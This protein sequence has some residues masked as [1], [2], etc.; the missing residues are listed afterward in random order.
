[1]NVCFVRAEDKSCKEP[2]CCVSD[3]AIQMK[4]ETK[5]EIVGAFFD[6]FGNKVARLREMY[7]GG[8]REEAF[9]L[10]IVYI[11]RLASGYYGGEVG[12]NRENFCRALKELSGNRLFAMLHPRELLEQVQQHFPD[13][14]SIVASITAP[15]PHTLLEEST[16]AAAITLSAL[17]PS[18][19]QELV[20]N[21]WRASIASICH[22]EIRVPEVHGAGSSGL[23]FDKTVYQGK[24]GL[25]IDFDLVYRALSSISEY[26]RNAS[27]ES[28]HWFG[29][30]NYPA[31][32]P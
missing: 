11:D 2:V 14:L 31:A 25:R 32:R 3:R 18:E 4:I 28:G 23:D 27:V 7:T 13:A 19:K 30:P 26:V 16:V 10:C 9:T 15:Q 20:D 24:V 17:E 29:N 1:M 22:A 12:K 8:F 5:R 21:L 6:E